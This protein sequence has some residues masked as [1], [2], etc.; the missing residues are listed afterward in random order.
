MKQGI[1]DI[2]FG[3]LNRQSDDVLLEVLALLC[4][5]LFNANRC[6]QVGVRGKG[7]IK[8]VGI[9]MFTFNYTY[10]PSIGSI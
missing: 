5:L 1:V 8:D 10:K 4:C 3:L 9:K 2:A 7:I 6:V